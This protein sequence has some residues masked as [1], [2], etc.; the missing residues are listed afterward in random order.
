MRIHL[1]LAALLVTAPLA[2]QPGAMAPCP[3]GIHTASLPGKPHPGLGRDLVVTLT[4]VLNLNSGQVSRLDA[5][6]KRLHKQHREERAR[7]HR[8]MRE[9]HHRELRELEQLLEPRQTALYQAFLRGLELGRPMPPPH[10][11]PQR[12]I[13]RR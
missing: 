8:A 12:E 13:T 1:M 5:E 7:H 4:E 3:E 9:R 10:H 11:P 6:L 2:A